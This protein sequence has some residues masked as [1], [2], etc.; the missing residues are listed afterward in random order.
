MAITKSIESKLEKYGINLPTDRRTKEYK[1]MAK[2]FV[3]L[4]L[5][6]L[7]LKGQIKMAQIKEQSSKKESKRIERVAIKKEKQSLVRHIGSVSVQFMYI[8]TNKFKTGRNVTIPVDKKMNPA[9]IEKEVQKIIDNKRENRLLKT[10]YIATITD[11]IPMQFQHNI[12]P[13]EKGKKIDNIRMRLSG[14]GLIDGYDLQTWDT[15]TGRC[16][17]DCII[18]RYGDIKGFKI[19]CCK[20]DKGIIGVDGLQDGLSGYYKLPINNKK[21]PDKITMLN[22]ELYAFKYG[23]ETFVSNENIDLIKKLCSNV[24]IELRSTKEYTYPVCV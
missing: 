13:V 21:I 12:R 7:N 24:K 16:V 19:I 6:T 15:N 4:E 14:A 9:N 8:D 23:N 20:T 17:F 2:D 18:H 3:Y 5:D 11:I 1:Q 22:K 10:D